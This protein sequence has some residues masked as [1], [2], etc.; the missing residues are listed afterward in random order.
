MIKLFEVAGFKNF[1]DILTVDFSDVHDY[2][3]RTV[4]LEK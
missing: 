1:K 3:L 4:W 2:Q